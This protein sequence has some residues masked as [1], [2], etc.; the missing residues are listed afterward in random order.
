MLSRTICAF[1][2]IELLASYGVSAV[3]QAPPHESFYTITISTAQQT[4]ESGSAIVVMALLTNTS[5]QTFAS[6][7]WVGGPD[8]SF[9]INVFDSRGK[10]APFSEKYRA[11]LRGVGLPM[12]STQHYYVGPGQ[13]TKERIDVTEQYDLS[14][15]DEYAIQVH[16]LDERSGIDVKSNTVKVSVKVRIAEPA[17]ASLADHLQEPA[18]SNLI[19]HLPLFS[20]PSAGFGQPAPEFSITVDPPAA[21]MRLGSPIAVVVTVTNISGREIYLATDKSP[22]AA[23]KDFSYLLERDGREVETTFFHRVMTGRQRADDPPQIW[24]GSSI[25]LPHPPGKIY[26]MTIDLKRLYEITEAGSYTLKVSRFDENT[27]TSV[28]SNRVTLKIVR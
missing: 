13:T 21:P 7:R 15:P 9:K 17:H 18:H 1:L 5:Q 10:P 14:T 22:N 26:V 20:T 3:T 6:A 16:R 8:Y 24:G 28:H 27:K 11:Q 12:G 19:D 25:A 2:C 23:Y 4:A